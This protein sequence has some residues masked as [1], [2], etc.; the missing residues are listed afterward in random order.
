[1]DCC[2]IQAHGHEEPI[3][4]VN[5]SLVHL[6]AHEGSLT[7]TKRSCTCGRH[8]WQRV[9]NVPD[10]AFAP[11]TNSH[12]D[13]PD[14]RF[15]EYRSAQTKAAIEQRFVATNPSTPSQQT[16][17]TVPM[18]GAN[19]SRHLGL[20]PRRPSP[21]RHSVAGAA[22]QLPEGAAEVAFRPPGPAIFNCGA[23]PWVAHAR[24]WARTPGG[25]G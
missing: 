13:N 6:Y 17:P 3:C 2:N 4:W 10:P 11:K 18:R 19:K 23:A 24:P 14:Q 7:E 22:P 1:M 5:C 16:G 9:D 8:G 20:R 12:G 21:V 15:Q 25:V